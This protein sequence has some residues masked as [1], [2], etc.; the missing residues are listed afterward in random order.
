MFMSNILVTVAFL[1]KKW[2]SFK[3]SE[4]F[5]LKKTKTKTKTKTKKRVLESE[6]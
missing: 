3:S 2:G 1:C 4:E 6:R 5:L